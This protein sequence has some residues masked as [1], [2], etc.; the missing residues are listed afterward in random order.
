MSAQ[1][2]QVTCPHCG[3]KHQVTKWSLPNPYYT[4]FCLKAMEEWIGPYIV[5]LEPFEPF[6]PNSKSLKLI[7]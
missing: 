1:L 2:L 6:D 4:V 5:V 3:Q 7:K